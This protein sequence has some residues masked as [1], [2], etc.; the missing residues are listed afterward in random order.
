MQ[1]KEGVLLVFKIMNA[2]SKSE[3]NVIYLELSYFLVLQDGNNLSEIF[4]KI[5]WSLLDT[6]TASSNS[7]RHTTYKNKHA[8]THTH[9]HTYTYARAHTQPVAGTG[10][11]LL[12]G[13]TSTATS[14]GWLGRGGG[15]GMWTYVLSPARYAVTTRI[16]LH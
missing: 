10:T 1:H 4:D 7:F 9:V 5:S 11:Y 14:Y 13:L 12:M 16:T 8:H 15:E 3:Q 6:I 2:S